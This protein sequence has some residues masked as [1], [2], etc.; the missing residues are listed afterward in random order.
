M[1]QKSTRDHLI[2]VGVELI[3]RNGY[4]ATGLNE[5]L[6]AAGVPKGSFYHHF[7]SK[8]E[9]VV[10][11]IGR[12]GVREIRR[13][14]AILKDTRYSPL[15][16]L[17][18]YFEE[19]LRVFGQKGLALGCPIGNLT[20]EIAGQSTTLRKLLSNAF[21]HWQ[22][23]IADVLREAVEKKELR[24]STDPVQLSA[25][26]LNSWEGALLRSVADKSDAPLHTFL[27]YTFNVLLVK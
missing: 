9:F 10:A 2:D 1:E 26:V 15:R 19:L 7:G 27:N 20:L 25:F 4:G 17:R 12:Y 21:S 22:Q 3:H 23:A 24:K 11:V 18:R 16:R 14:E 6:V 8:E 5:I 13:W